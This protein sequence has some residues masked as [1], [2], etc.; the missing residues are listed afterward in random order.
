MLL[1]GAVAL[2]VRVAY[3]VFVKRHDALVGD[4]PYFHLTANWLAEGFGFTAGPHSG[5]PS[6]LHPPLYSLV[7]TPVSWLASG[8][9]LLAQRL[10]GAVLGT[11][12]VVVIGYLGR[13]VAR[14]RVGLVAAVLAAIS[15]TLW[16]N[17]GILMSES[18][19]ALLVAVALLMAYRYARMPT[20]A[21][22]TWMGVVCGLAALTRGE[23]ILLVPFVAIPMVVRG[24]RRDVRRRGVA[25]ASVLIGTLLLIAPWAAY[26]ASRFARPVYVSSNLG[27][28]LCG[29]NNRLTYSGSELGLWD[30]S[31][32]PV[33]GRRLADQSV[34]DDFW[35]SRSITYAREHA[36]RLPVVAAVRLA[37]IT[38]LYAPGQMVTFAENTGA[39]PRFAS[40]LAYGTS[41]L[42]APFAAYGLVLLRRRKLLVAPLVAMIGMVLMVAVLLHGDVRY[43]VPADVALVVLGA[44][45]ID[46]VTTR[47]SR[48]DGDRSAA[49]RAPPEV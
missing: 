28:T 42:L 29:A 27:G 45:G 24:H 25:L 5:I 46:G 4:E 3:V 48:H 30:R 10:A 33:P 19:A 18:L 47:R 20:N 39:R 12:T 14:D 49:R 9:A 36:S 34:L 17:D 43:R 16:V 32:C 15:P 37:R 31:A 44:A 8:S 11:L 2:A 40:W 38:G 7:L 13:A 35:T 21:N 6:A 1:I 23:L 26:N 22:A 41:L